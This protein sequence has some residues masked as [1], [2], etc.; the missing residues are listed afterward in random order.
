MRH[1]YG[2]VVRSCR[3]L[4]WGGKTCGPCDRTA[5]LAPNSRPMLR[6]GSESQ[7]PSG[8]ELVYPRLVTDRSLW[9]PLM[10]PGPR[11]RGGGWA[12]RHRKVMARSAPLGREQPRLGGSPSAKGA[13]R[14]KVMFR[15]LVAGPPGPMILL[16]VYVK[17][18]YL[19]NYVP[20]N[21]YDSLWNFGQPLSDFQIAIPISIGGST[22]AK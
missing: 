2:E 19:F 10:V 18:H 16:Q 14:R 20:K 7:L 13:P 1:M 17:N 4:K 9:A 15:G 8:G 12:G 11:G 6:G 21:E 22:V 3:P 5:G